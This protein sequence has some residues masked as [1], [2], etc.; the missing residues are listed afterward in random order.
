MRGI[1]KGQ[2]PI[3]LREYRSQP[4]AH[5]NGPMFTPVKEK[6][7]E[8]LL[9][10]QGDLCA[11]CMQR[12]Y[13]ETMKVEHWHCQDLYPNEDLQYWN[14][15][16]CCPGNEGQEGRNQTCDTRKG[17]KQLQYNPANASHDIVSRVRY[18]GDGKIKAPDQAFDR[19]INEVLNLNYP[20]LV[21]NRKAV[22]DAVIEKLRSSQGRRSPGEIRRVRDEW[23]RVDA[24]GKLPEYC[25]VAIYLLDKRL[26]LGA[27]RGR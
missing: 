5:Y 9:R 13:D 22:V 16:G 8:R 25:G 14:L 2:E 17:N 19:Q 27:A 4:G 11:Y 20:R 15:L 18:G 1:Q 23:T 3:E 21:D 7:R 24:D 26:R 12:I 6:I 10:D